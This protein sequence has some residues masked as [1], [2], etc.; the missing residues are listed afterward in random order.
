M[1][2]VISLSQAHLIIGPSAEHLQIHYN[3]TKSEVFTLYLHYYNEAFIEHQWTYNCEQF[4]TDLIVRIASSAHGMLSSFNDSDHL[5]HSRNIIY[6]YM[7]TCTITRM[8]SSFNDSDH[9][10]HSR[11]IVYEYMRTCT[12]K[13][14]GID[15]WSNYGN[16]S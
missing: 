10:L 12:I 1:F 11:N 13:R 6:E 16:I 8:L 9:L 5:L 14:I 7:R 3:V 2:P 15:H 4:V